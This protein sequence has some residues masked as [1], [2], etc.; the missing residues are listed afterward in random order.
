MP[1]IAIRNWQALRFSRHTGVITS[2]VGKHVASGVGIKSWLV[3]PLYQ[4]HNVTGV[5]AA[6][7][8][9]LDAFA[10]LDSAKIHSFADVLAKALTKAASAGSAGNTAL[11]PALVLQL[12]EHMIPSLQHMVGSEEPRTD[13]ISGSKKTNSDYD[14]FPSVLS[15]ESAE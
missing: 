7:S 4:G 13:S 12:I 8:S 5:L 1:T 2:F 11:E 6:F 14:P 3:E 15:A 10:E 9:R